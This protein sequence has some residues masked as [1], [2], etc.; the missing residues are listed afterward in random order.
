MKTIM[1]KKLLPVSLLV[2]VLASC[3]SDNKE[4]QETTFYKKEPVNQKNLNYMNHFF[5]VMK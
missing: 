2:L 3:G 5:L 4:S 1:N